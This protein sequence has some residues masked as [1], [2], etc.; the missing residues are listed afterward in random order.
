MKYELHFKNSFD[1]VLLYYR[2]LWAFPTVSRSH[3][4]NIDHELHVTHTYDTLDTCI[5]FMI[6]MLKFIMFIKLGANPHHVNE[7]H[8]MNATHVMLKTHF[9]HCFTLFLRP[10]IVGTQLMVYY[11]HVIYYHHVYHHCYPSKGLI[12]HVIVFSAEHTHVN[13]HVN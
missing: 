13:V 10:A 6:S 8:V 4:V 12:I 11:D 1:L 7:C 2:I 9:S 3:F 5:T